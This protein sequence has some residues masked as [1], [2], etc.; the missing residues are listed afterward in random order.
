MGAC[1]GDLETHFLFLQTHRGWR[2][3]DIGKT[4]ARDTERARRLDDRAVSWRREL[5]TD[6]KQ[7]LG[8]GR[9]LGRDYRRGRVL[10]M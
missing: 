7:G 9:P 10:E 3:P 8:A 5:S 4:A 2:G 1:L 6:K